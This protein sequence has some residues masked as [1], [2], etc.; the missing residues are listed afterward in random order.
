VL[1]AV[2]VEPAGR[3]VVVESGVEFRTL[4]RHEIE[5]YV[6]T[7]EPMDKAGAYAIQGNGGVFVARIDGSHSNI[8][9]LPLAETVEVLAAAGIALPWSAAQ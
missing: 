1:T 5:W 9:G 4:T 3:R 2:A 6:A 8:I 7:G